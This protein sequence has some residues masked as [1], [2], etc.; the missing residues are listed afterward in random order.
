MET[1]LG[2]LSAFARKQTK[3]QPMA[4]PYRRTKSKINVE[5]RL[6][7]CWIGGNQKKKREIFLENKIRKV[8]RLIKREREFHK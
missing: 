8:E 6:E 3:R 1:W 4:F 5:G 7:Q 2:D